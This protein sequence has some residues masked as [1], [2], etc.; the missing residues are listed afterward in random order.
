MKIDATTLGVF[1]G[2]SFVGE[3][4]VLTF[5]D[6]AFVVSQGEQTKT[7]SYY[8]Y[9][10]DN[11]ALSIEAF[12][13]ES[14]YRL[15]LTKEA[16]DH[17]V[18]ALAKKDGENDETLSTFL[19][20]VEPYAGYYTADGSGDPYN[21]G[22][23]FDGSFDP[24]REGFRVSYGNGRSGHYDEHY[25]LRSYYVL[26]NKKY[27]FHV[28]LLD[29]DN[30]DYLSNHTFTKT[31][32][33][34]T[35]GGEYVTEA[36]FLRG[37][38]FSKK[39]GEVTLT[40]DKT[41]TSFS[42]DG[43]NSFALSAHTD[44]RG[45]YYSYTEDGKEVVLRPTPFGFVK[46][47]GGES[48][49]F[50][51]DE[52]NQ[53]LGDYSYKD[54]TFSYQQT[55]KED[56]TTEETL[57]L[58]GKKVD[59]TLDI[60]SHRLAFK[61]LDGNDTY[62]FVSNFYQRNLL[63][64]K[65]GVER[66]YINAPLYQEVFERSYYAKDEAGVTAFSVS[67]SYQVTWNGKTVQGYLSYDGKQAY[68]SLNFAVDGVDY[69]LDVDYLGNLI[70]ALRSAGK[71][72]YCFD[73]ETIASFYGDYTADGSIGLKL[74]AEK[75]VRD[76]ESLDYVLEPYYHA[77]TFSY[78]ISARPV[79]KETAYILNGAKDIL[80]V[81]SSTTKDFIPYAQYEKMIGVY[82]FQ[83]KYGI[84][85]LY[86]ESGHFY[87][88]TPKNGAL[89]KVEYPFTLSMTIDSET[90]KPSPVIL[91]SPSSTS[92]V[93]CYFRG[94]SLLVFGNKYVREEVYQA[95]GVYVDKDA[96]TLYYLHDDVLEVNG[97]K[98]TVQDYEVKADGSIAIKTAGSTYSFT[99]KDASYEAGDG[100]KT[101]SRLSFDEESFLKTYTA[102]VDSK[103]YSLEFKKNVDSMTGHVTYSG[104]V[105]GT[106]Y[107]YTWVLQD[108]KPAMKFT[109]DF[110]TT[111]YLSLGSDGALTLSVVAASL[112][113]LPPAPGL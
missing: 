34:I 10:E 12:D 45:S 100:T 20:S 30:Y 79:G 74:S 65:N 106:S 39:S 51:Y 2:T 72:T 44:E 27:A 91:F 5:Q 24:S 77:E 38:Y 90:G 6:K 57:L 40:M 31:K 85:K 71:T 107:S 78:L 113:P 62:L 82:D 110:S 41:A 19:P 97:S 104:V 54:E 29:S 55:E 17:Y 28:S 68:V 70:F 14:H 112:P 46:E 84:E 7:Y 59:Y 102:T 1:A 75:L 47:T 43:K 53:L 25:I 49:E 103:E 101:L 13:E 86:V 95:N 108:G 21:T 60:Y 92:Q 76:G 15:S 73:Q 83:S 3:D 26:E 33:G 64:A 81:E 63:C 36:G 87:A 105:D 48:E 18:L 80:A 9:E 56:G 67:G 22:L 35:F 96:S 58:N 109:I 4:G 37:S 50:V 16:G 11:N 8:D 61:V 66:Y 52:K 98:Q 42:T 32:T 23:S 89:E 93:V 94:A 88:D 99:K 69:V 111:Y